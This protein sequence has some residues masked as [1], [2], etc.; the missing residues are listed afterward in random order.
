MNVASLASWPWPS[1]NVR[2][3]LL[4]AI[5]L[6]AAGT[7][8]LVSKPEAHAEPAA[9]PFE[10]SI[11]KAF[12]DWKAVTSSVVQ[13]DPTIT[14]S[15][16]TSLNQPY[17]DI[18]ARTYRNSNGET[19]MLSLA[20]GRQQRQEVKIHRPD[21]CYTAQ[22][23]KVASL[24]TV[25]MPVL[26]DDGSAVEGKRM[27]AVRDARVGN[28]TE[29]VSYWMR[30]GSVYSES[31]WDTRRHILTEGIAGRVP[32]G[33]L[34]RA[35]RLPAEGEDEAAVHNSLERFLSELVAAAPV[36]ARRLLVH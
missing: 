19:V 26:A 35:S 33:V 6:L 1:I 25:L 23:F 29:L 11:P 5:V 9:R 17:D 22:G 15:G 31:A 12:G 8:A 4:I 28:Y 20:Y 3:S 10:Q 36:D 34:V 2:A 16:E 13:V 14:R 7:T 21:L 18:L 24:K 27:K 30:V 32:D